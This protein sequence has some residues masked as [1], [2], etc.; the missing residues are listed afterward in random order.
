M[1]LY[2]WFQPDQFVSEV[3]LQKVLSK[4]LNA[5]FGADIALAL[6][7]VIGPTDG[8]ELAWAVPGSVRR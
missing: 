3:A 7:C 8:T 4:D 5:G 1:K 6:Q 2:E